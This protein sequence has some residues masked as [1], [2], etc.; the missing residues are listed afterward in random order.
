MSVYSYDPETAAMELI[1]SSFDDVNIGHQSFDAEKNILY[2]INERPSL[3]GQ[4]GGGGYVMALQLDPATGKLSLIN[5]RPSLSGEPCYTALDKTKRYLLISHH[6]D[7]GF[8]T[9]IVKTEK[10]FASMTV[11][12]DT[13]LT[14]FRINEDGSIG[15]PC[16]VALTPGDGP[17]GPHTTSRHHS[18]VAD[19]TGELFIACDKGLDK[20]HTFGIDRENGKLIPLLATTVET[21]LVPRYGVF[22]PTLPIFYV[23]FERKT[24]VRAYRYDIAT[25]RLDLIGSAPLLMDEKKAEGINKVESADIVMHPSGKY[26]YA[27][28]RGINTIAVMDLDETGAI[29]LRQDL[30]CGGRIPRGLYISPDTRFLFAANMD[31]GNVAP[32]SIGKDG[33]LSATGTGAKARTP[34]SMTIVAV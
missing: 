11:F 34:G 5:E 2:T 29:S 30:D 1:E 20:I 3:K 16:D 27:S 28:V 19:P 7:F 33:S 10:G 24:I 14:L 15:E 18:I 32:F 21:G 4:T 23:N 26:I 13:A 22:H 17:A 12:D 31:S 9:K 25:G 8:V 6:A